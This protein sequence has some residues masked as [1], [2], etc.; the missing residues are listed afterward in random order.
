MLIPLATEKDDIGRD[1]EIIKTT[2]LAMSPIYTFFLREMADLI[3]NGYAWPITTW[4]DE[5]CEAIYA[6][7]DGKIVGHIV[8]SKEKLDKKILWITLSAVDK[9][10]RGK[11]IYKILHKHFEKTAIEMDCVYIASQV[12]KNNQPRLRSAEK[13]DM[14]SAFIYMGKKII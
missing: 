4:K 3:D 7:I 13:V 2:S 5:D 1:V 10:N 12:H 11:G 9:E 8:Y 6:L 14:K